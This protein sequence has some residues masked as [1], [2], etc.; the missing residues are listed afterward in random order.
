VHTLDSRLLA[1]DFAAQISLAF[2]E[3]VMRICPLFP[4]FIDAAK[5]IQVK[6]SLKRRQPDF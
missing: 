3:K 4:S 1:L 5:A 6:L 2:L